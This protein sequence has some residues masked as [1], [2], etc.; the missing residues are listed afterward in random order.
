MIAILVAVKQELKPILRLADARH[1][2]RQEHFDFYEG[3]LAGEP[4][5]LLALGVGKECARIAAEMT[6]KCYRPDLIINAGFGG[7]LQEQIR[8]GDI[9]IGSEALDLCTDDGKDVRCRSSQSLFHHSALERN[10]GFQVHLG[11]ML[12]TDD[13]ILKA[14]RKIRM[15]NATG[16]LTVDMETSAIAAVAAAHNTPFLGLRCIT[17][18]SRENLPREFNDFFVVGQLQPSRILKSISRR[19]RLVLDLARMGYRARRAGQTLARFLVHVITQIHA[20]QKPGSNQTV[21]INS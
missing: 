13:M 8:A 17:D 21:L 2:I 12:T 7:A 15:G 19:P 10:E 4:V 6:V 14:A 3:T 11:K 16:A 20:E 5:A 1:I 9:V 18:T